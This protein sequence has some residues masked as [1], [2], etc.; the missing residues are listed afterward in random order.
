M[1]KT[2]I[3]VW[4]CSLLLGGLLLAAVLFFSDQEYRDPKRAQPKMQTV[5][6]SLY[7]EEQSDAPRCL[8]LEPN[9]DDGEEQVHDPIGP[10][11]DSVLQLINGGF[12]EGDHIVRFDAILPNGEYAVAFCLHDSRGG[13]RFKVQEWIELDTAP[14][15]P[16]TKSIEP[17]PYEV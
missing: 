13:G 5:Q 15:V 16:S 2:F 7:E 10:C 17:N 12:W 11:R 8:P 4:Q 9:R 1:R 3:R 6:L 14:A